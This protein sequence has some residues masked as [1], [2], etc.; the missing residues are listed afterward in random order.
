MAENLVEVFSE[1]PPPDEAG[2]AAEK[3]LIFSIQNTY[4][5]LRAK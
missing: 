2:L 1:S 4:Y 3:Y 5:A